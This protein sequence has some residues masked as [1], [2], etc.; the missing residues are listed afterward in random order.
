MIYASNLFNVTLCMGF[1]QRNSQSRV[2]VHAKSADLLH[3]ADKMQ[4]FTIE[5]RAVSAAFARSL[6]CSLLMA[7][8]GCRLAA[9]AREQAFDRRWQ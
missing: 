9:L 4:S 2:L 8:V 1:V 3:V 5:V 7:I 6:R